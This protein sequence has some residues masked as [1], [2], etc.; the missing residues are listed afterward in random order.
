MTQLK[1]KNPDDQYDS[2]WKKAIEEYFEECIAFF[3]PKIH[4]DIN[5]AK[6][7]EFLDKE[8]ERVVRQASVTEQHVD[9]LIQV[10]RKSG[11]ETWVLLHIDVQSQHETDFTK[12]MYQYNYRLFDRYNKPVVTVVIYGDKSKKWQPQ[13]Y[14][15]KLWGTEIRF[16]FS[17]IKLMN[18]SI[19]ELEQ[20][21]N[22]FAIVV[23]AHLHTKATKHQ[24]QTRYDLRWR[25]T[26]MLYEREYSREQVISLYIYI[27]WLMALPKKLELQFNQ[28]LDQYEEEQKM[29]Y[30]ISAVRYGI[31]E[32][33]Q[34]GVEQGIQQ[35]IEEG[36]QQGVEQGIQQG[37]EQGI[38]QGVEQ[39][40]QQGIQQSEQKILQIA[41]ED[42]I[43]VLM[44]RFGELPKLLVKTIKR[45]NELALL[46]T[47]HRKAITI[48][49]VLLFEQF[50]ADQLPDDDSPRAVQ[51]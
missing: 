41:R 7:Y 26:R 39:G 1:T 19:S 42:V 15:R 45:L 11:D 37:V 23:L 14:K 51:A 20:S 27:D 49:T 30:I 40:I 8:L 9:K 38:Q 33:I 18:Y 10:H 16:N 4:A 28:Q 22:P 5:W 31:E 43:E 13:E 25:L 12:R 34:Q 47:L 35:G 32:G 6:E 36:I 21:D 2:P 24:H 17:S 46:K 48:E 50:L 29:P 44:I 3:F